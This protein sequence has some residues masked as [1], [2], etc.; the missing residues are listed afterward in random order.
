MPGRSSPQR[1]FQENEGRLWWE[2]LSKTAAMVAVKQPIEAK[3]EATTVK[4]IEYPISD[5]LIFSNLLRVASVVQ[6]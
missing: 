1:A 4:A 2:E 5:Y 6:Y 3:G